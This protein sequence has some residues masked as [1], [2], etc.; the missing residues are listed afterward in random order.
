MTI[1]S[2][3]T[4]L[5]LNIKGANSQTGGKGYGKNKL[6]SILPSGSHNPIRNK[7]RKVKNNRLNPPPKRN[8]TEERGWKKTR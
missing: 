3:T 5:K 4:K 1:F 7:N 6:Y 2:G 8:G